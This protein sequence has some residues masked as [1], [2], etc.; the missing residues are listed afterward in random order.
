MRVKVCKSCLVSSSVDNFHISSGN[1][2]GLQNFCKACRS[3]LRKEHYALNRQKVLDQTKAYRDLK[4]N[5][6]KRKD[7]KKKYD[8]ANR[9][10]CNKHAADRR[11]RVLGQSVGGIYEKEIKEI[12]K[13][14]AVLG[15][16]VDHIVPLAGK[17]ISGLHVP[18]NLQLLSPEDNFRKSNKWT[19][20]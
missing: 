15:L 13:K 9:S 16:H 1:K 14:A 17:Q 8:K 4:E 12:Y 6:S 10:L 18:W 3:S 5:K 19:C 7:Y 20:E 11:S 2:D